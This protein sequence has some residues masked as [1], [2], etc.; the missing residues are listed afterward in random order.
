MAKKRADSSLLDEAEDVSLLTGE[1]TLK[2]A[3]PGCFGD[4]LKRGEK[5][6]AEVNPLSQCNGLFLMQRGRVRATIS[7][8]LLRKVAER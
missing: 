1:W 4:E 6:I 3:I 2:K 7:P 5:V 8:E